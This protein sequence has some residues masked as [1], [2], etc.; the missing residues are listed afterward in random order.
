MRWYAAHIIMYF[1]EKPGDQGPAGREGEE[2][3]FI[4][5]EDIVLFRG[6]TPAEAREKAEEYGSLEE[7][8][9][10]DSLTRRDGRQVR[11]VFGGVRQVVECLA[12]DEKGALREGDEVTYSEMRILGRD[13]LGRLIGGERVEVFLE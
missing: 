9:C 10:E 4:A 12:A 3:E 8:N 2:P 5:W 6:E 7:R 1:E 13:A 11:M